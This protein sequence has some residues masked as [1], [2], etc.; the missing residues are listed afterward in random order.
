[1]HVYSRYSQLQLVHEGSYDTTGGQ[2]PCQF[3]TAWDVVIHSLLLYYIAPADY[4]EIDLNIPLN[5]GVGQAGL[6]RFCENIGINEDPLAEGNE[7]F[8][9]NLA[10]LN[11]LVAI[12]PQF[13]SATVEIL[14]DDSK[15]YL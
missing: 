5:P 10:S 12:N 7:D 1:M 6:M 13:S 11:P 15:F 3:N 4:N 2:R 14:D 9:V 8:T